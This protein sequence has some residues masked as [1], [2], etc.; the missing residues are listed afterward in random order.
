VIDRAIFLEMLEVMRGS[1]MATLER[2]VAFEVVSE[3]SVVVNV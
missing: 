1:L 3:L 2:L